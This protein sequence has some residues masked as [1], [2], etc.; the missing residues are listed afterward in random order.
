MRSVPIHSQLNSDSQESPFPFGHNRVLASVQRPDALYVRW[1][2][3][4]VRLRMIA[5]YLSADEREVTPGLR[6]YDAAKL[7]SN[8]EPHDSVREMYIQDD[9]RDI[10]VEHLCP[11]GTYLVDFGLF[12]HRRFCPV[13]RSEPVT[14][15]AGN[16]LFRQR[17]HSGAVRMEGIIFFK[18]EYAR[19]FYW[20]DERNKVN[21]CFFPGGPDDCYRRRYRG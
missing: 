8:G 17:A 7:R 11:G 18:Q 5:S 9:D 13:L 16:Q 21:V 14:L 15:P 19:L 12:H 10:L 20:P 1:D 2:I 6:I 4:T 3:S